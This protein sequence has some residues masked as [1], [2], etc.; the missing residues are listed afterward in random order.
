MVT[1]LA[2]SEPFEESTFVASG[3]QSNL[4]GDIYQIIL[5]SFSND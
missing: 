4:E 1:C 2:L 5:W 3:S